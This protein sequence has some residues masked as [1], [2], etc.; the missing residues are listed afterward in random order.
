MNEV[1]FGV[2]YQ[3]K[4]VGARAWT[5]GF[6]EFDPNSTDAVYCVCSGDGNDMG[7]VWNGYGSPQAS[8]ASGAK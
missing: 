7:I 2:S 4:L 5:G 1:A 8:E 6:T 3:P